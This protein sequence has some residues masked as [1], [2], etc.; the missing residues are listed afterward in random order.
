M[1]VLAITVKKTTLTFAVYTLLFVHF[2][3]VGLVLAELDNWP[4]KPTGLILFMSASRGH[5]PREPT[6]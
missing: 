1:C 2:R 4:R 3:H 6:W 5:W